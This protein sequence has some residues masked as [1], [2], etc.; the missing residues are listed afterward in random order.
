ME[1]IKS[2]NHNEHTELHSFFA[3]TETDRSFFNKQNIAPLNV[4][5]FRSAFRALEII[6]PQSAMKWGEK[7]FFTPRQRTLKKEDLNILSG[8]EIEKISSRGEKLSVF[9][10]GK[11]MIR[12]LLLLMGGAE[13]QQTLLPGFILLLVMVSE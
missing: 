8:A 12:L 11:K 6:S 9:I 2:K 5:V 4:R 3:R 1:N 13:D 10:W 7:L